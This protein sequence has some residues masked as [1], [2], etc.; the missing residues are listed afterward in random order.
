MQQADS[1]IILL[2]TRESQGWKGNC[3]FHGQHSMRPE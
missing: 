2:E 3:Q 1:I